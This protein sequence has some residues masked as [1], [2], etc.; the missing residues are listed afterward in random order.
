M[1][2]PSMILV[3]VIE[4]VININRALHLLRDLHDQ[5]V[6]DCLKR[7]RM[8]WIGMK[9]CI[10]VNCGNRLTVKVLVQVLFVLSLLINPTMSLE[11]PPGM[12]SLSYRSTISTTYESKYTDASMLSIKLIFRFNRISLVSCVLSVKRTT[13]QDQL[14]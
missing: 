6:R 3:K 4:L 13:R 10:Q 8:N 5:F 7:Y 12:Q 9:E 2:S 14:E 1:Y 11:N